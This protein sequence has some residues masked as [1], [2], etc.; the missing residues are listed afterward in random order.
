MPVLTP[1]ESRI[2]KDVR[3]V[4]LETSSVETLLTERQRKFLFHLQE[5]S[6]LGHVITVD[7][8][9]AFNTLMSRHFIPV[10]RQAHKLFAPP[11]PTAPPPSK[12]VTAQEARHKAIAAAMV[13]YIYQFFTFR[14]VHGPDHQKLVPQLNMSDFLH[15]LLWANHTDDDE[16][17]FTHHSLSSDLAMQ[18]TNYIF[19]PEL[20]KT[21]SGLQNIYTSHA[22]QF[23][24]YDLL[25]KEHG[26]LLPNATFEATSAT[27][28]REILWNSEHPVYGPQIERICAELRL[29]SMF[30]EGPEQGQSLLTLAHMLG[31]GEWQPQA[32]ADYMRTWSQRRCL[33]DFHLG[34]WGYAAD[35]FQQKGLFTALTW[36][37]RKESAELGS[38]LHEYAGWFEQHCPYEANPALVPRV[39]YSADLVTMGGLTYPL[40][41]PTLHAP[42]S[43]PPKFILF[44]N[45][46]RAS[47][48]ELDKAGLYRTFLTEAQYTRLM[49]HLLN[50][51]STL[52]D[53][54]ETLGHSSGITHPDAVRRLSRELYM[55]LDECK[56]IAYSLHILGLPRLAELGF[57]SPELVAASYTW[58]L[59]EQLVWTPGM[60]LLAQQQQQQDS[61]Q[62]DESSSGPPPP[63]SHT[64]QAAQMTALWIYTFAND[65]KAIQ[66]TETHS[67]EMTDLAV[68]QRAVLS[69]LSKVQ[70]IL[71]TADANEAKLLVSVM[72]NKPFPQA[73][74]LQKTLADIYAKPAAVLAL[75]PLLTLDKVKGTVQKQPT[76]PDGFAGQLVDLW[77]RYGFP[78]S[79]PPPATETKASPLPDD[80]VRVQSVSAESST[81]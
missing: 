43:S 41:P 15:I 35:I 24:E 17:G 61:R 31:S 48:M 34:F 39:A 58:F 2:Q 26:N 57:V 44:Y 59:N 30:A 80:A 9:G 64:D 40:P 29:A 45:V 62:H 8:Q 52:F 75:N 21:R 71:R 51:K 14:G 1:P 50:Y 37:M 5:A 60:Y 47:I 32:Q 18:I 6:L 67:L 36:V 56:A 68:V 63:L 81:T 66:V 16:Q 22:G 42:G 19:H 20:A 33:V 78:P 13:A 69:F 12:E 10:L 49:P 79:P 3:V 55:V 72:R 38:V 65:R 4:T 23:T 77:S 70:T 54:H 53:I 7:Q 73:P 11:T 46:L 27:T 74:D 76:P 25:N 28:Y